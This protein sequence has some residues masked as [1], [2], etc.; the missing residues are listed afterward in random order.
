MAPSREARGAGVDYVAATRHPHT[1]EVDVRSFVL[2]SEEDS[3]DL[4]HDYA[5]SIGAD[6]TTV[7]TDCRYRE[8]SLPAGFY[9][10]PGRYGWDTLQF[11]DAKGRRVA[12]T[13][14]DLG[15]GSRTD[16]HAIPDPP[17]DPLAFP[18]QCDFVVPRKWETVKTH[19]LLENVAIPSRPK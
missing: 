9:Q 7:Y 12:W 13:E 16:Q 15:G 2:K 10:E 14:G 5:T 6:T 17:G 1:G 19:F 3:V 8:G 11:H 4:G 18:I